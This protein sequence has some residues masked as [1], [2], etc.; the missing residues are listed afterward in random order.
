M[1]DCPAYAYTERALN[2]ANI[3]TGSPDFG[4]YLTPE[5]DKGPE[6]AAATD[7]PKPPGPVCSCSVYCNGASGPHWR[8]AWE[9]LLLWGQKPGHHS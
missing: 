6:K 3:F 1:L 7:V 5:G 8:M 4:C 9:C 2:I